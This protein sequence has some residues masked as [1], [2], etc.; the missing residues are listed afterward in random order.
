M[1]MEEKIKRINELYHKSQKEGLSEAERREQAGLRRDFVETMK[2]NVKSGLSQIDIVEQSGEIV[3]PVKQQQ[4]RQ[5]KKSQIRKHILALRDAMPEAERARIS[6]VLADRI[7][8]HQWFY[9]AKKLLCFVS[10]GSEI[11]TTPIINE[12]LRLGKEVYV[13]KVEPQEPLGGIKGVLSA[14]LEVINFYQI[15]SFDELEPG[16]RKI[17]EPSG[18]SPKYHFD[19]SEQDIL[20]LMPGVAFDPVGRRLGYGKGFYDRFLYGKEELRLS[21]IA[22]GFAC[23]MTEEIP[24]SA[25]DVKPYQIITM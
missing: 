3:N 13:P 2:A 6:L 18:S 15:H 12:A 23:Q 10:F 4:E 11:D 22:I 21:S 1:T 20:M 16:Y 14:D 25:K 9:K 19:P 5:E 7:I 8:G 24:V 17:P